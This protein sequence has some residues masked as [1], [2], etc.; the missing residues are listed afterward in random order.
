MTQIIP[1]RPW[2]CSF[3]KNGS[4]ATHR[5]QNDIPWLKWTGIYY[6]MY[7]QEIM[8]HLP[9]DQQRKL[10]PRPLCFWALCVWY[11][12]WGTR[13]FCKEK[14]RRRWTGVQITGAA[15]MGGVTTGQNLT[16]KVAGLSQYPHHS[17]AHTPEMRNTCTAM[18]HGPLIITT[19]Y[20][21]STVNKKG[22]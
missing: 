9:S 2:W 4:T 10:L 12:V 13:V 5:V 18:I 1:H 8:F 16:W 14:E 15:G 22:F 19:L 6:E 11:M 7:Q 20:M 17:C 3:K 21:H